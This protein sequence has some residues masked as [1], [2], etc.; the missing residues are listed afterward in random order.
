MT[1]RGTAAMPEGNFS[2]S[3]LGATTQPQVNLLPPEI[4]SRRDLG[5]VK[6]RLGIG[7][8]VL[9]LALLAAFGYAILA[10]RTASAELQVVQDE[11]VRLQAEQIRYAE[12]PLVKGQIASALEGRE[13]AMSTEVLWFDYL[14][15]IQAVGPDG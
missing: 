2:P 4:R 7:L 5:R 10:E 14:R 3:A 1:P 6:V 13:L 12:V 11:V 9:I 8:V 15:A